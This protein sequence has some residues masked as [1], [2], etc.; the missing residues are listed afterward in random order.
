MINLSHSNVFYTFAILSLLFL[1]CSD[2]NESPEL[3]DLQIYLDRF[4]EEAK[5]RGYDLDLSVVE[6]V[7]VDEIVMRDETFCGYGYNNYENTSQRKIEISTSCGWA[8]K[9]DI[10]RENLFFHEIGHAFLNRNHDESQLCDGFPLSIMTTSFNG[11]S[12]YSEKETEKRAYYISE[13]IDKMASTDKCI[14]YKKNWVNDSAVYR[15]TEEDSS[16][17]FIGS[18][19]TIIGTTGRGDSVGNDFLSMELSTG[20]Q[21]EII[22]KWVSNIYDFSIPECAEVTFRVTMNS[23]EL[24]GKGAYIS[25]KAYHTPLEREG[26]NLEPYLKVST[27]DN[28]VSGKLINYTEEVTIPCFSRKTSALSL[29]IW[30][31]NKNNGKISFKDVELV[32]K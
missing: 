5:L 32:V 1:S 17:S 15:Y 22:G 20:N 10:A 30:V 14:D 2:D 13:L 3:P 4:E 31:K 25:L 21:T 27:E 29:I 9:N 24:V 19:E 7:Y 18:N 16:W 23:D 6:A 11:W 12:I 8:G 28:P 26:A